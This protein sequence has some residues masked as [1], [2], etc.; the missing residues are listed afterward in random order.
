M[1]R[2][3]RPV[4]FR[5]ALVQTRPRFGES[6]RN[7]R[8]ALALAARGLARAGGAE[9]IVLPELFHS[10]YLFQTRREV[11]TLA[12]DARDG[13]T[14]R[15]LTA[16]AQ[17][18]GAQIVAGLCE[19]GERAAHNSAVLVGARGT[20]AVYRKVHLF[21]EEKRWFAPGRAAWPVVRVGAAR[22]GILVC[23]DW[24]F[25][26]A[27]RA[28]ALDGADLLAHPSNLVMPYCQE[29]MRTRALENRIFAATV[30]RVGEDVRGQRRLAFTGRS[31]LVD[32]HGRVLVRLGASAPG[33]R[34]V[35]IDL[36]VARDKSVTPRNDLFGDRVPALYA[37]LARPPRAARR[38]G[39]TPRIRR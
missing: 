23:F 5:V 10:G 13:E 38:P 19:R 18:S 34:V 15:A 30:N 6:R 16:F 1:S 9:L 17:A 29:A 11:A 28:L 36:A 39:A 26:E 4:R 25:P 27:A 8:E 24:R 7:V 22:V 31:Q 20:R 14:V 33:C 35:E 21:D 3:A 32:P 2:R 12:E 37:R